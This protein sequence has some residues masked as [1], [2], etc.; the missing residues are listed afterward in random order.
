LSHCGYAPPLFFNRE[1]LIVRSCMG[2]N[3]RRDFLLL[4]LSACLGCTGPVI[5]PQSPE[6]EQTPEP[7]VVPVGARARPHGTNFIKLECISLVTGLSGTGEDPA[8]S[9]QRAAVIDEMQRR[10]IKH[11]DRILASPDTA[12]VLVR[13]FLKPGIQKGDKFDVEVRVPSRSE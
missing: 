3:T 5:R 6:S 12:L 10:S 2:M 7:D 8:P 13:G 1:S 9:V 4:S 11:A